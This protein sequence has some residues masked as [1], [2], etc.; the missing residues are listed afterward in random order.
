MICDEAGGE[1]GLG[2][3]LTRSSAPVY[4]SPFADILHTYLSPVGGCVREEEKEKRHLRNPS[5]APLEASEWLQLLTRSR[6][7]SVV[8]LFAF[9]LLFFHEPRTSLRVPERRTLSLGHDY[10]FLE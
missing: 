2:W 1:I 3:Q 4:L 7:E 6:I 5:A 10:F 8:L 9:F